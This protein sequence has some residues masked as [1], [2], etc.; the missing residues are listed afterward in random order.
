MALSL[1]M[2][3]CAINF[4]PFLLIYFVKLVHILL[5]YWTN[6]TSTIST[7]LE[8][9]V[10]HYSIMQFLM[11][12]SSMCP[13]LL[14]FFFPPVSITY[15]APIIFPPSFRRL[16]F[17]VHLLRSN[18]FTFQVLITVFYLLQKS[19]N[20]N[21]VKHVTHDS[22]CWVMIHPQGISVSSCHYF[23]YLFG[24]QLLHYS[25]R[26]CSLSIPPLTRWGVN[27]KQLNS[28]HIVTW[29]F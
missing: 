23:W 26:W 5:L 7:C 25:H 27:S 21:Q 10:K 18:D 20:D 16:I 2:I 29:I 3:Q 24:E 28:L 1:C 17:N 4:F 8:N 12:W 6:Q 9:S 22:P 11:H 19:L 15:Y 14:S 13:T